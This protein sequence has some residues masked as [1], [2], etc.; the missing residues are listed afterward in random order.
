MK[1]MQKIFQEKWHR[2]KKIKWEQ[3]EYTGGVPPYGYQIIKS[4]GKRKLEKEEETAEVV[5]KIYQWYLEGKSIR[6]IVIVLELERIPAPHTFRKRKNAGE[7]E[8]ISVKQWS[9]SEVKHILTNP[10]YLGCMV[11]REKKGMQC[12]FCREEELESFG[13]LLQKNTHSPIISK[14]VF[15]QASKRI[16]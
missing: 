1:C 3:G 12:K 2:Q 6:E 13:C 14:D 4:G 5:K 11:E 8:K 9:V 16:W 7:E 10:V 15:F